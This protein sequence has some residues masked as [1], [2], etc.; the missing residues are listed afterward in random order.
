M[1]LR[2]ARKGRS[3]TEREVRF[4][5]LVAESTANALE[6]VYLVEDL[7]RANADLQRMARTDGLTGLYNR[8]YFRQRLDEEVSRATRYRQPL[9]CLFIDVDD[10]KKINDRFGHLAGDAVLQEISRRTVESTR[11]NDIV[12]RYG[13]E[14]IVIL[15]PHTDID[16]AVHQAQRL[17]RT[18]AD[19]RF[20]S[21]GMGERV[22]VSVG[23]AMFDVDSMK[24]GEALLL[25]ADTALYK[26]KQMGK[27]RL[28]IGDEVYVET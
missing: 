5:E 13:G 28:V 9:A 11:R 26:A 1:L 24:S 6:R 7:R 21:L 22:T 10:F 15:L 3:F 14:E 18:V 2:A 4:C 17:I 23:M 12:A 19:R 20:P 25:A 8:A 27:N 16:G